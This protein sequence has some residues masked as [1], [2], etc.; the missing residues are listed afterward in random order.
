MGVEWEK[1][2]FVREVDIDRP[3]CPFQENGTWC[4]AARKKGVRKDWVYPRC[5]NLT[6]HS[7]DRGAAP[8][9]PL[10]FGEII[11]KRKK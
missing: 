1:D 3:H 7:K 6:P 8:E 9:C 11:I 10:R 4:R 5:P 2:P